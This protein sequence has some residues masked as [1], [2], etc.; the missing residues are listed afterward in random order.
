MISPEEIP[1]WTAV[2]VY[3]ANYNKNQSKKNIQ[4]ID[5]QLASS[6]ENQL[7]KVFGQ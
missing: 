7:V 3:D 4:L 5:N 1:Y 2:S 6:V